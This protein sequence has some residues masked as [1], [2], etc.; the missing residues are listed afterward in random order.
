MA[1]R[2]PTGGD[3]DQLLSAGAAA[4]G[5]PLDPGRLARFAAYR[6][7]L[8]RWSERMNLTALR[9]PAEVVREG[10]LDS[11]ACATLIPPDPLRTID[12]G[13]GAGFPALPLAI[14][15]PDL[16]FTLVE[17]SRKKVTFLRHMA[18]LL[19]LN[20]LEVV[21]SRAEALAPLP[22]YRAAYGLGLA[23]AMA[24]P[25]TQALLLAPFL[26][27]GGIFLAQVGPAT[28]TREILEKIPDGDYTL[29]RETGVP[30]P[31]GSP[32][33]RL[34]RLRRLPDPTPPVSRET[35]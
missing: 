32:G 7:E 5:L 18:R 20:S 1:G 17:A 22:E 28:P 4:L 19:G 26:A 23:R 3:P 8:G 30:S 12:I 29:E 2:T 6:E 24:H 16:T 35:G 11:L 34:L 25:A 9:R 13:S 21:W 27:P 31:P 15:R 14:L 33:H 10:F